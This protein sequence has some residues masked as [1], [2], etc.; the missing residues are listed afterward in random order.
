[1]KD[2]LLWLPNKLHQA[3]KELAEREHRSLTAQIIHILEQFLR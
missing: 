3:L 2:I 1:M